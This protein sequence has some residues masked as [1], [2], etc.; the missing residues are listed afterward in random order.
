MVKGGG[1]VE[2]RSEGDVSAR[3]YV[4]VGYEI[5]VIIEIPSFQVSTSY[6]DRLMRD[7]FYVGR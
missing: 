6:D 2:R 4:F 1:R 3:K 7:Y 5:A